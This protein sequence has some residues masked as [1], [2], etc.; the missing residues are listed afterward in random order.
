MGEGCENF[1][2]E[3]IE[4]EKEV[5][6]TPERI[7]SNQIATSLCKF[8]ESPVFN[9]LNNLSPIKP[10][11]S[12]HITQ[13]INPLSFATLPSV[14]TSPHVS[15]LRGSRFL[16]RH[17]FSDPSKPEFSSDDGN[18]VDLIKVNKDGNEKFD[19]LENL[20]PE[21][22]HCVVANDSSYECSNKFSENF[23]YDPNSRNSPVKPSCG[24]ESTSSALV[25]ESEV[26]LEEAGRTDE[27][28][29]GISCDWES[30]IADDPDLLIF[31]SP[32]DTENK[33]LRGTEM[34]FYASIRNDKQSMQSLV[35]MYSGEQIGE[36]SQP[37]NLSFHPGEGTEML[38]NSEKHDV[39]SSSLLNEPIEEMDYENLSGLYRGMRRRCLDFEMAGAHR[40]R[41]EEIS[42]PDS[43]V[44]LQSGSDISANNRQLVP[45]NTID[46]SPRCIVPTLGLHLNALGTTSKDYKLVNVEPSA[47]G[48][49]LIGPIP[50]VDFHPPTTGREL[51]NNL[52][53]TSLGGD[54]DT[55]E[56]FVP[57]T[58]DSCQASGYM[59]N[60]EITQS[61]PKKKKR[62]LE[63]AGEGE[64]CKRCNCK[65]SKCLKLYCECFAAGVY[66]VESCACIDCFNKP[67]HEGTV[68][69]TRKQIESRNPLAFAPKVIRGSDS[70]TETGDD[71][72]NTPASARHKRGCN[73]KKSGCLKKY[74][75]CYQGGVGCSI[76]CRCEG[77]KNVF[78]RKDG[79]VIIG[80]EAE[81]E[82]DETDTTEKSMS[83]KTAVHFDSEQNMDSAP[84]E[85]P[86][87]A[88]RKPV[89]HLF[90]NQK[91]P[92]SSFPSIGSSSRSY[93]NQVFKKPSFQPAPKFDRHFETIK[94]DEIPEFL[95]EG[96]PISGIKLSSP[97]R[98]RVSPPH[99]VGMS[100]GLRSSRKLILQSI[101]SFPSLTHNQ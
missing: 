37:E 95:Q 67:V 71:S 29:E 52:D 43:S 44:V 94:E 36:G 51:I 20:D 57:L 85:T 32:N 80:T 92:R 72:S 8:E 89:Q 59:A 63:Q 18:T 31:E 93:T 97:N 77:C 48:R 58:E 84:P 30:L 3:C 83:E 22:S 1:A 2:K 21:A 4:E 47:S 19:E 100:T 91:P 78:G 74:C 88:G 10:V 96:S 45:T 60:E 14:F 5:M 38:E 54:M 76:N 35:S 16:R 101:P 64:S 34:S 62:R 27:N 82:E 25:Y 41:F 65:K 73:C 56:D 9:F 46:E 69:A 13:T 70:L 50:S 79:S 39:T 6:D 40:Q 33:K 98:K 11:K 86:L 42:D 49:F 15:S 24:L 53:A 68:L 7:K 61:S 81:Y 17:Q 28:K 55:V 12:V 26:N 90:S 99:N 23:D 66:C 87:L 75:E